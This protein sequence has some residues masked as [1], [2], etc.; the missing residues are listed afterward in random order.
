MFVASGAFNNR[1]MMQARKLNPEQMRFLKSSSRCML[2]PG[3][4]FSGAWSW[5]MTQDVNK[6]TDKVVK[7]VKEWKAVLTL[8]SFNAL[9]E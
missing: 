8:T 7:D 5:S 2:D 4:T 9:R 6:L 3:S 1:E